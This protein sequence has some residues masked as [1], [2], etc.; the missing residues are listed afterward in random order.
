MKPKILRDVRFGVLGGV[1]GMSVKCLLHVICLEPFEKGEK[2][3][4]HADCAHHIIHVSCVNDDIGPVVAVFLARVRF[5]VAF[6]GISH[7]LALRVLS[8][9]SPRM[10][11][12]LD[13]SCISSYFRKRTSVIYP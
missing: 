3:R 7:L 6:N 4:N 1:F 13:S 11:F 2:T 8:Q 9:R 10:T 12:H 5:W